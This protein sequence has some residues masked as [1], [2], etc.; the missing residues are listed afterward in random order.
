MK[1]TIKVHQLITIPNQKKFFRALKIVFSLHTFWFVPAGP[2]YEIL[3]HV[4]RLTHVTGPHQKELKNRAPPFCSELNSIHLLKQ[5]THNF[6]A[7]AM[8]LLC[9]AAVC[10][11]GRNLHEKKFTYKAHIPANLLH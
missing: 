1:M 8:E 3:F 6:L 5:T 7:R 4:S 10:K 2:N 11:K 9:Y